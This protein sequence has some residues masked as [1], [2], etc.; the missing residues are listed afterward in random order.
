[1]LALALS[2]LLFCSVTLA[3]TFSLEDSMYY[4]EKN[5]SYYTTIYGNYFHNLLIKTSTW[6]TVIMA[7]GRF[8]AICYPMRARQYMRPGHTVAAIIVSSFIWILLLVPFLWTWQVKTISCSEHQTVYIL[9]I[10]IYMSDRKLNTIM[11]CV[12]GILGVFIPILILA[13]CNIR[14]IYSLHLSRRMRHETVRS[15]S[16]PF[17]LQQRINIT[18]ISIVVMFFIFIIPSEIF[19]FSLQFLPSKKSNSDFNTVIVVCNFLQAVNFS[20]NFAL[21]CAVNY[22]FRIAVVRLIPCQYDKV[23]KQFKLNFS[24]WKSPRKQRVLFS[25]SVSSF[26]HTSSTRF[27]ES[28]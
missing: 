17:H 15:N 23:T 8:V 11:T 26:R 9:D 25:A 7:I 20:S 22:Y 2:D 21:Y 16:R 5:V 4:T 18:L 27:R 10:G 14:L 13:Y 19:N 28:F 1:M 3:V 12:W 24:G 6:F